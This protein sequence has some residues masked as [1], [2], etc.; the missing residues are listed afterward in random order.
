[1]ARV[2]LLVSGTVVLVGIALV[3]AFSFFRTVS[4]EPAPS[5]L[6]FPQPGSHPS[7]IHGRVTTHDGR[8]YEGR[9]R[10]GTRE[11]AFW[12][13][14]FNGTK[15]EN[16]WVAHVPED[17]L[18]ERVPVR[19]LGL[20]VGSRAR[21]LDLERPFMVRFGD[22]RRI[23]ATRTDLRVTLKSGTTFDL[24]LF[25]ADDLADG[26]RVWTDAGVVDLPERRIRS[27]E[28]APAPDK[29]PA[30]DRLFGTVHTAH[31]RFTGF[32]QWNREACLGTDHLAGPDGPPGPRFDRIRSIEKRSPASAA[33]VLAD[34]SEMIV[35]DT[36]DVGERN[37]GVFVDDPRVGGV[38][39]SWKAIE[40]VD[41]G[42]GGSGPGYDDFPEG[43]PL[44]GL[45]LT[46]DGSSLAGRLVFDLDES[47]TTE[48]LDAPGAG[49]DHRIPFERIVSI[50]R[51]LEDTTARVTLTN[52]E[53]LTLEAQ[54]DLGPGNLG[55]LV[56]DEEGTSAHVPWAE[57][58]RI[59]LREPENRAQ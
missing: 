12:G 48:T 52:G 33:I 11:E 2:A 8:N 54:G 46:R 30:P 42:D 18:V 55:L 3:G 21:K 17:R 22:I 50:E 43:R 51:N 32:L 36:R 4:P 44:T 40:R 28:L 49:V 56:F 31:G 5:P 16:P 7:F 25:A 29:G 41:L 39:V 26:V 10:W 15:K 24:D 19:V 6:T 9:L 23:E 58:V 20:D 47:E 27:I 45:V 38:L 59:E 1:M 13:H 35:T 53:A 14:Y 34:G 57:V 37:R